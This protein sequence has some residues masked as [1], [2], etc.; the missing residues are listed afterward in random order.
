MSASTKPIKFNDFRGEYLEF[1]AEFQ[2]AFHRVMVSGWYILGQEVQNFE[3]ELA[4]YLGVKY[5]IGVGNG[6]EALQL[7]L[8]ALEIGKGDEVITTPLSAVATTLAILAV[9]ATPVFIDTDPNGQLDADLIEAA[10][11][12]RTKAIMPVD[13]Y[14]FS[15]NYAKIIEIAKK[16][17][18]LVIEDAAQAIGSLA[19]GAKLGTYGDLGCFSFY[20]TKNLGAIGDGGAVVTNNLKLAEKIKILRDYGQT[21]KYKH[22]HYGLNSR[23]DELQAA[24]LRHKLTKLDGQNQR[25]R[26][27][28]QTYLDCLQK[29]TLTSLQNQYVTQPN[30]H[31]FILKSESR[32]ELQDFLNTQGIPALVHYPILIPEQKF[33]GNYPHVATLIPKAKELANKILTIPIHPYLRRTEIKRIT[34][35]LLRYESLKLIVK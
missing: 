7:S 16:N 4:A 34:Q 10:I 18:L 9:G 19:N 2:S 35:A 20:P 28:A 32:K 30:Y 29:T 3:T 33:I 13:L 24:I 8:M 27:I 21:A 17:K 11:T 15:P 6:L 1:K 23:L 5:A 14:G 31:L 12:P 25:R 22:D 26:Q